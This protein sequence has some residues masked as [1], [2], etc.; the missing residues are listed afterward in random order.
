[1][2]SVQMVSN[3]LLSQGCTL[4]MAPSVGIVC[5]TYIPRTEGGG[6]EASSCTGPAQGSACHHVFLMTSSNKC[7]ENFVYELQYNKKG[8]VIESF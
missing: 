5:E 4:E 1:M 8:D 2:N 6:K 7:F 3:T